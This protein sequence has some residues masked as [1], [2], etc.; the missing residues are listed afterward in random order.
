MTSFPAE[1]QNN[2]IISTVQ[3]RGGSWP[4]T[5]GQ[6]PNGRVGVLSESPYL[7][8]LTLTFARGRG[9]WACTQLANQEGSQVHEGTKSTRGRAASPRGKLRETPAPEQ[10]LL[11][12]EKSS[13][14]EPLLL[15]LYLPR[16]EGGILT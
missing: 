13:E 9:G 5:T 6:I 7:N 1:A 15:N 4:Q 12:P 10:P 11:A 3:A 16:G 8:C 14:V 2:P